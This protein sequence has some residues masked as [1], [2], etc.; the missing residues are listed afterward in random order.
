M[1]RVSERRAFRGLGKPRSVQRQQ[2]GAF[3]VNRIE[4][5]VPP[6]KEHLMIDKALETHR[7]RPSVLSGAAD[8]AAP[9][10]RIQST[11]IANGPS[12]L[13]ASVMPTASIDAG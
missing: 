10:G 9:T 4:N 5:R 7:Y 3:I 8:V 2:R 12:C 6:S 11:S 1:L 13:S